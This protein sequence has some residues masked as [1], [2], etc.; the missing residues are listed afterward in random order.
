MTKQELLTVIYDQNAR[1]QLRYK[2][3]SDPALSPDMLLMIAG[4]RGLDERVR[5]AALNNRNLTAKEVTDEL[6]RLC[7]DPKERTICKRQLAKDV[8]R[9]PAELEAT[10]A[11]AEAEDREI[12]NAM[13][14]IYI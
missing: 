14:S 2:A 11:M 8:R 9:F 13:F 6:H 10:V 12:R 1:K 3:V 7:N 5:A 4:D